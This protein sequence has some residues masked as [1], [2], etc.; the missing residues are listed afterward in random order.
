M[1]DVFI[2]YVH[3]QGIADQMKKALEER[4]LQVFIDKKLSIGAPL[5]ESIGRAMKQ[6][7]AYLLIIDEAFASGDWTK[8]EAQAA[9]L[10]A[11]R[12]KRLFPLL[13]DDR[14]KEFWVKENPLFENFLGRSWEE[15]TPQALAEEIANVLE[16]I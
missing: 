3:G 16:D 5:V 7:R 2:S 14:A 13:V 15:S 6:S 1:Y 11:M 4:G 8:A 9:F 10:E 12:Q